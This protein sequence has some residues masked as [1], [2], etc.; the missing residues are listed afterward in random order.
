[1]LSSG[2]VAVV[3][4]QDFDAPCRRPVSTNSAATEDFRGCEGDAATPEFFTLD[5]TPTGKRTVSAELSCRVV[6][7]HRSRSGRMLVNSGEVGVNAPSLKSL[8]KLLAPEGGNL[9]ADQSDEGIKHPKL[10]AVE[11]TNPTGGTQPV[12]VHI[13]TALFKSPSTTD[14]T[15]SNALPVDPATAERSSVGLVLG[16]P[17]AFGGDE[18][19]RLTYEGPFVSERK[20]GF[21]ELTGPGQPDRLRDGDAAFC[22]RGVQDMAF[23]ESVGQRLGVATADLPAFARRHADVVTVTQ[24]LPG[25]DASYWKSGA[26][27]SCGGSTGKVAY[28]ECREAFGP[29]DAP[30]SLRDL[31][32][33]EAYHDRLVVEPR[34]FADEADRDRIIELFHCCLGGGSALSYEVRAGSQWVLTGSGSGFRHAVVPEPASLRCIPDCNPRRANLSSRAFEVSSTACVEPKDGA[35][36][37][38]IGAATA[39]DVAC[40]VDSNAPLAPGKPGEACVYHSLTHRFA[41]YR[42]NEPSKRDMAFS[43][44]VTGGFTPLV[45]NLAAQSRAVS[46]QTMVF[47]PQIG[48]LAVAD[49]ASQGL[50]LVSLDSVSVSRLFF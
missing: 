14:P 49:G 47:V 8:P 31:R 1:M 4:V 46:P 43:W 21:P 20:T 33:V 6:E 11:F 38:A 22:N 15:P 23:A 24:G 50:V 9:A 7:R 36:K 40:V 26:G 37:C 27:A 34:A 48:Q 10:L 3:D 29:A 28:L 13:G 42:G 25:E 32:I 45:A 5:Q 12:E 17:R 16:E 30:T 41:V 19:M 2:Q 44:F 18:E 39:E 35:S